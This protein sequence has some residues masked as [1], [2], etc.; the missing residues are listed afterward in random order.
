MGVTT[1][2][3]TQL[4][5]TVTMPPA[6]APA[7]CKVTAASVYVMQEGTMCGTGSGQVECPDLYV[8]DASITLP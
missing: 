3:W 2:A 4:M 8:D 6:N 1:G 5:G 7:G